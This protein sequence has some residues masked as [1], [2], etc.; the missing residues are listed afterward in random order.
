MSFLADALEHS[1]LIL[2]VVNIA[3]TRVD[4]AGRHVTGN[5]KE[6]GAAIPRLDNGARGI[7]SAC[8]RTGE[9]DAKLPGNAGVCIGHI[10]CRALVSRRH[11]A[12]SAVTLKGII[13][14]NVVNTDD[15]EN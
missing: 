2:A 8:T 15:S 7:A 14:R 6:W 13:E 10:H 12:K 1:E 5:V 11:N 3:A 4:K 9:S